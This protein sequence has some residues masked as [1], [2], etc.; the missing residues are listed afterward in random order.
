MTHVFADVNILDLSTFPGVVQIAKKTAFIR[1]GS[2]QVIHLI[3]LEKIGPI[4]SKIEA[5]SDKIDV[6][7][8]FK[9]ILSSK[10][11]YLKRLFDEIKPHSRSKRSWDWIGS[12]FKWMGGSPDADDLYTI[13][14]DI[15]TLAA[16]QNRLVT[17]INEQTETNKIFED[18]INK[19]S[20]TLAETVALS[21]NASDSLETI[22]LILNID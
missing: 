10:T 6:S 12:S 15:N 16:N 17:G 13:N 7:N 2:F 22:N 14:S 20:E 18:K 5:I 8:D 11:V 9:T 19:I 3:D 21:L 1:L 4:I